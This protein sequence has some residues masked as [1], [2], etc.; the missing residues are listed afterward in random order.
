MGCMSCIAVFMRPQLRSHSIYGSCI[1]L[2]LYSRIS[3]HKLQVSVFDQ[4]RVRKSFDSGTHASSFHR[5]LSL[6]SSRLQPYP[7][8]SWLRKGFAMA[9]T[10]PRTNFNNSFSFFGDKNLWIATEKQLILVQS[11]AKVV[12]KIL[13]C[14][15]TWCVISMYSKK[16]CL[17]NC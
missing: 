13:K 2:T 9:K 7:F 4:R 8:G 16:S 15:F 11:I 14:Y 5:G 12:P 10:L 17:R 3:M 1:Y 6:T